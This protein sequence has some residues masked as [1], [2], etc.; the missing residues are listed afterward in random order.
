VSYLNLILV[1]FLSKNCLQGFA[2]RLLLR[3]IIAN[4]T[5]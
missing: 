1:Q 2:T 3:A 5:A 4:A